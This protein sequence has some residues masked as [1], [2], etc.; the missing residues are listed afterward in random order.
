MTNEHL[1]M[2]GEGPE[3]P[4]RETS[5]KLFDLSGGGSMDATSGTVDYRANLVSLPGT[6]QEAPDLSKQSSKETRD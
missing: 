3:P 5:D 1:K 4:V 2:D 6:S